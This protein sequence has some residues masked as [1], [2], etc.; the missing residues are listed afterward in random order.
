VTVRTESRGSLR[1]DRETWRLE[2]ELDVY[3]DGELIAQRRWDRE[4]PRHL[5]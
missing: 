1:T 2:L 5:Q 3:E 4:I